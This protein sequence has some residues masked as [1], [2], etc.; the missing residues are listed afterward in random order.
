MILSCLVTRTTRTSIVFTLD[1]KLRYKLTRMWIITALTLTLVTLGVKG[2]GE[3]SPLPDTPLD[4]FREQTT[5]GLLAVYDMANWF[6]DELVQPRTL[7]YLPDNGFEW[8]GASDLSNQ[9]EEVA[10]YIA[11]YLTIIAVSLVL[12]LGMLFAAFFVPCCRCCTCCGGGKRKPREYARDKERAC[13]RGC[14]CAWLVIFLCA[15]ALGVASMLSLS[16]EMRDSLSGDDSVFRQVSSGAN[17]IPPFIA[18]TMDDVNQTVYV[19]AVKA[20]DDVFDTLYELPDTT[21][22]A[23]NDATGLEQTF[24]ELQT[25][26]NDLLNISSHLN[27]SETNAVALN[28]IA[29][30]LEPAL[31]TSQTNILAA[32]GDCETTACQDAIKEV[33]NTL[34]M[35]LDVTGILTNITVLSTAVSEIVASD[36]IGQVDHVSDQIDS[37][38][39]H[40]TNEINKEVDNARKEV[41]RILNEQVLDAINNVNE[42]L[43]AI[44]LDV[45]SRTMKD[46]EEIIDEHNIDNLVYQTFVALGSIFI[47]VIVLA[48]VGA[49]HVFC[50][51]RSSNDKDCCHVDRAT[52]ADWLFVAIG[53]IFIFYWLFVLITMSMFVVVV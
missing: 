28:T 48:F 13:H 14:C 53:F 6:L 45:V 44:D 21:I 43:K 8:K 24:T 33:N 7:N 51:P 37:T 10:R 17:Q 1:I 2:Q 26:S 40:I 30:V 42:E 47:L 34:S 50:S 9:W 27:D 16:S 38:R 25:F 35:S 23:L 41:D 31:V 18:Q 5:G 22:T 15:C 52:G 36:F 46:V 19:G 4:R 32:I 12:F 20:T 39:A 49:L 3:N 11:G 29:T